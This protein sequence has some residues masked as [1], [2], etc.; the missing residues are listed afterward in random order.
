MAKKLTSYYLVLALLSSM[1]YVPVYTHTCNLFNKSTTRV[2]RVNHCACDQAGS[3]ETSFGMNCCSLK[4]QTFSTDHQGIAIPK[5]I[6]NFNISPSPTGV[7]PS[8]ADISFNNYF[9]SATSIRPPPD[10]SFQ[11]NSIIIL[12]QVFRI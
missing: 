1:L 2:F 3:N 5:S 10:Q 6:I 12:N 9:A 4:V 8:I 11:N 7:I